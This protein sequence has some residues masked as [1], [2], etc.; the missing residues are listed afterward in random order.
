MLRFFGQTFEDFSDACRTLVAKFKH[1]L[2]TGNNRV[3]VR[4]TG[5]DKVN[6]KEASLGSTLGE[7]STGMVIIDYDGHPIRFNQLTVYEDIVAKHKSVRWPFFVWIDSAHPPPDRPPPPATPFI[8]KQITTQTNPSTRF[9]VEAVGDGFSW[10]RATSS[11]ELDEDTLDDQM[12][13]RIASGARTL[14][15]DAFVKA[16]VCS[17]VIFA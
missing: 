12:R 7:E 15:E 16:G 1:V 3:R 4:V 10:Q 14:K 9:D 5:K 11:L 17:S 2:P 8:K 6:A 13:E